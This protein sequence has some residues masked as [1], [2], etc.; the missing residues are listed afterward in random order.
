[1]KNKLRVAAT[2]HFCHSKTSTSRGG[3][4]TIERMKSDR[5]AYPHDYCSI[6]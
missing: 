5:F 3:R 4:W 6:P 2:A 1:M